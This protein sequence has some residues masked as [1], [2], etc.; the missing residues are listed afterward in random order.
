MRKF[1]F[2]KV[3]LASALF[4]FLF[5]MVSFAQ[6]STL[7]EDF[8]AKEWNGTGYT[9]RTVTDDL[10]TWS[11]AGVC[12][13]TD[14]K[15][16]KHGERSIRFRGKDA[17]D[18]HFLQMDFDKGTGIGEASF[19][20][21]SYGTHKDG[22]IVLYYSTDGGTSW[23]SKGS[24]TAPAWSGEMLKASFTL[25]IP[26]NVRIKIARE[27]N[28]KSNT[29]VNIDDLNLTDFE[30]E[31]CVSAPT[32]SP[33]G[34][35]CYAPVSVT[36]SCKTPGATIRYTLDG[37]DP[38]ESS[39]VYSTPIP[40]SETTTIKAKAWKAGM[41]ESSISGAN[42]IF[43]EKVSTLADLRALAPEYKE[44][45]NAGTVIYQYTG[46]AVVTHVQDY[47][48]VRYIQDATA[49]IMI[50]DKPKN[51]KTKWFPGDVVTNLN[52]TLSNYWG[53][54]EFIP[55][56]GECEPISTFEKVTP[57][58]IP[59]SELDND[60]NN[61]IQ[62][63][64]VKLENVLFTA[65]GNFEQGKY[66]ALKQNNTNTDSV[67]FNDKWEA[68]YIGDPI[69]NYAVSLIG[70]CKY[71]RS[72]NRLI[73]LDKSNPAVNIAAFNKSVIKLAPNPANS[74]VNIT[75]DS[76]MKLEI[77][78]LLGNLITVESLNEGKN[79]ISV[80]NYPAGVYI[81]K[82]IDAGNGQTFMQK[83]VIK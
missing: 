51:L 16:H 76:Y 57:I 13:T 11:V 17:T 74:Y 10:G 22:Q 8:E 20:Y 25:N 31:N 81:M 40:V 61:S 53:L 38:D 35:I 41:D 43:P 64:V 27:G 18:I 54:V 37:S 55:L 72:L 78:S 70:V 46:Q 1:T 5:T 14:E 59:L 67:V 58:T 30:C 12:T 66:Y 26:G 9:L 2:L 39:T 4:F 36:I 82:M 63:K 69:P 65:S 6:K 79:T 33:L 47:D 68:D 3:A 44:G 77:Y 23:I 34:G 71:A 28:L 19:Y 56:E 83:L 15:D 48:N 75:T 50:Y 49:A 24:V 45:N 7:F 60:Y 73:M 52:G 80:A 32:F 21:A 42:Y 62:A 29:S